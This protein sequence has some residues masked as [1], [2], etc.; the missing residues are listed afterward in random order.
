MSHS[1]GPSVLSA[2]EVSKYIQ[3]VSLQMEILKLFNN[4]KKDLTPELNFAT[5]FGTTKQKSEIA[6]QLLFLNTFDLVFRLLQEF[7]LPTL[8]IYIN[9][10]S[11][12]IH[13]LILSWLK[14][15]KLAKSMTC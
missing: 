3:T 2:N 11:R 8:Q 5:I 10:V 4:A 15:N 12:V 7:R 6:E 14:R 9:A 1:D 13:L